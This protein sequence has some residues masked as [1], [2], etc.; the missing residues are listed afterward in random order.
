MIVRTTQYRYRTM[1]IIKLS[2]LPN[3]DLTFT[4]E[5]KV[6]VLD[7]EDNTTKIV[8]AEAIQKH[9]LDEDKLNDIIDARLR[10]HG[11]IT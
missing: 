9:A 1:P 5:D 11:L 7:H 8:R 3:G 2:D 10:Y 6:M 4:S